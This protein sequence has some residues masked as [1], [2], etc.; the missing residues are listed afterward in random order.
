MSLTEEDIDEIRNAFNIEEYLEKQHKHIEE[1]KKLH[2]AS[3]PRPMVKSGEKQRFP[4][5]Q[6]VFINVDR[7]INAQYVTHFT[8]NVNAI[9]VGT[10]S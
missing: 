1:I 2:K 9:V 8:T 7:G 4:T 5:G 6:K 10:C 3:P